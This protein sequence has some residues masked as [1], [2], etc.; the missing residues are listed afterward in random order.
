MGTL[1]F[2]GSQFK[3]FQAL[4]STYMNRLMVRIIFSLLL[5]GIFLTVNLAQAQNAVL[6]GFVRDASDGQ[7]MQSV[8]VI[9]TDDGDAF[10]GAS[11]DRDGFFALS[12]IPPGRY[13]L[14]ASFIGYTSH[15]DTLDFAPDDISTYNFELRLSED[16]LDE[17][18]VE[19]ERE[20]SGVAGL[21][22][23]L[24]SITPR[25]IALIPSPDISGDLASYL[26]ALPGVVASGD[27]GGQLFIRGGEPTQNQV[28][29]DGMTIFQPFHLIGFYS[30]FPSSILNVTDVYAGG[31]GPRY[32]GRLSS[33]IDI[34]TRNGNKRRV[35]GE[36]SAAPFISAALLEGPI[37]SGR[38]SALISGR[39]S[40][41]DQGAE[42]ILDRPLP[43]DFNDQFFK[44][45][46][47][48]SQNSQASISA[49]RSYDSGVIGALDKSDA[50]TTRNNVKWTSQAFGARY[51]LLPS[52]IPVQAELLLS[53]SSVE[54][55]F[56]QPKEP[57]R[58]SNSQEINL[59]ANVTH[60][61]RRIDV[62]W[63]LHARFS[64]LSSELGGVFQ[65][66]DQDTEFVSEAGG[67]ILFDVKGREGL[68][69]Q[70]GVRFSSF[71]SKGR[72]FIEPRVRLVY[73][74]SIHQFSMAGGIYHQE[75]VGLT[76]RRDAGDVFTAWTTSPFG[77]VPRAIHGLAGYQIRPTS[78]L[79]LA[80]EGFY[81]SMNNLSIAE[82]SSFPR[83][84]T[85][86]QSADGNVI[87]LDSRIEI[88]R[89]AFY[90]FINYGYAKVRYQAQQSEIEYWFGSSEYEFSPPHD[91][92]HQ[93][94]AVG[95]LTWKKFLLNVRWQYGSG[96]P[97]SQALGFDEFILLNGP[98]DLF[99]QHGDTR[100]LYTYPYGGRLPS[101]H[102][103][104]VSLERTFEVSQNTA[105]S[106]M[107]SAT[108]S[109][110]RT[111]L[112]YIDLFTL[113][114][115]DQL[116]FIPAVGLKLEF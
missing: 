79:R 53:F 75:I 6:R 43:Y 7:P 8:N 57:S 15:R 18:V 104:D 101:Y 35:A 80:A 41:I 96:L 102:R 13:Y 17:L 67:Y 99:E 11:T 78:W 112:F 25:E 34:S 46:A 116:P 54:N 31:F 97:F 9:L 24:Q 72:N 109:Y 73:N 100:V 95:S 39:F 4:P 90:G 110:D 14:V 83:F 68:S 76:D 2:Y 107:A 32:G 59:S 16:L 71:P 33:V 69:F 28:L 98:T 94:N 42:R 106:I 49:L 103:L 38:V 19:S 84:T 10:I 3:S 85:Q 115:L 74:L 86:L 88:N 1:A 45:H 55:T 65:N 5:P 66:L 62:S 22:G 58:S 82:W 70:P 29:L 30:A 51:I 36:I 20:G 27:Q 56:G 48:L 23:G 105:V 111:N 21:T 44:L 114:R 64:E 40:V 91:R 113:E 81:K 87:G 60:Y 89:G 77:K 26:A 108:N 47:D 61:N 12:G 37:V 92:K 93:L 52:R 50:D 63:G